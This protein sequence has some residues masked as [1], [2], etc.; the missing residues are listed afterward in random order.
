MKYFKKPIVRILH[1]LGYEISHYSGSADSFQALFPQ[2]LHQSG[3]V[4]DIFGHFMYQNVTDSI[5]YAGLKGK[6]I[7]DYGRLH[8]DEI[9]AI[10]NR[11]KPAQNIVDIGANIGLYTLLMA[12]LVGPSGSVTAFE[13]GPLSFSFLNLNTLLNGYRNIELVNKGVALSN[14]TQFYYSDRTTESGSTVASARPNFDHPRESIPVETV[15]LDEYFHDIHHKIDYIKIDIEGGE[16]NALK[17]MTNILNEMRDIWLT[18]EYAP[19]LPLWADVDLSE[20]LDFVRSHDFKI[21][22]LTRGSFHEQASDQYLLDT[23]PKSEVGKYA[24][25]LLSRT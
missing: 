25:L 12:K 18:I 5:N 24:N 1:A 9:A 14:G 17:G 7:Q 21:H 3:F 19:Y 8:T 23:Y 15:S 16:Y 13:P 4:Y 2:S 10:I 20:F 22:D 6:R 11:V